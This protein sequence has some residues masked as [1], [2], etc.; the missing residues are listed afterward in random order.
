MALGTEGQ[1]PLAV[2]MLGKVWEGQ[3]WLWAGKGQ[4]VHARQTMLEL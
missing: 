3:R 2:E 1:S 4:R